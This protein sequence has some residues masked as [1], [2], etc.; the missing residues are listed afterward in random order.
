MYSFR[1][2][3]TTDDKDE[4]PKK[5]SYTFDADQIK[6]TTRGRGG[7]MLMAFTCSKCE[8]KQART[9]SKESYEQGVVLLRCEGCDNLHLIAD[10]L[11]WFRDNKVNIQQIMEEKGEKLHTNVSKDGIEFVI[12]NGPSDQEV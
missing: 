1:H 7:L 8:T 5:V 2:F 6:G 10:N 9:F 3:H 4:P 12:N 11:G